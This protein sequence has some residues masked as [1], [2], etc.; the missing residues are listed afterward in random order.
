MEVAELRGL[1]AEAL[2]VMAT[3]EESEGS[4]HSVRLRLSVRRMAVVEDRKVVSLPAPTVVVVVGVGGEAPGLSEQRQ[5]VSA[6][7]PRAFRPAGPQDRWRLVVAELS[8]APMVPPQL[9]VT[10]NGAVQVVLV[11]TR[12]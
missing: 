2:L 12:P 11:P 5:E 8:E 6:V 4:V 10:A 1:E 9:L 3:R 7:N